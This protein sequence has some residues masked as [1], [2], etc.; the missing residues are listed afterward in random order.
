MEKLLKVVVFCGGRGAANIIRAFHDYSRVELTV[1]V[2]AFDDGLSTGR[3][4]RFIPGMLGPSDVRKNI[5]SLIQDFDASSTALKAILEYRFPDPTPREA[6]L[7]CLTAMVER[8]RELPCPDLA[9]LYQAL[10]I[11]QINWIADYLGAFLRYEQEQFDHG[12]VFEYGDTSV[13]NLLFS[14]CHLACNRDF[15]QASQVFQE[16]CQI[17]GRVLNITDGS[18]QVLTGLRETGQFLPD[19]ATIVAAH[20]DNAKIADLF[21]LP[22]YLTPA[23]RQQLDALTLSERHAWLGRRHV[24]PNL[25]PHAR[26]ALE[27][28]DLIIYGPGTQH[29]SLYP[30]YMVAGVRRTIEQNDKAEKVFIGNIRPDHDIPSATVQ[31]LIERFFY[32][33]S[34][35]QA[36]QPQTTKLIT[37]LFVQESDS[38]RIELHASRTAYLPLN[39]NDIHIDSRYITIR[40]WEES[41]GRHSGDQIISE[42][43]TLF[44]QLHAFK[45]QPHRFLVS[46]VVPALNEQRTV[47]RVL[48]ELIHLDFTPLGIG[49]E[50]LFIDGGSEDGTLKEA[51]KERFVRCFQ[52]K[53]DARGRGAA[54]RL[55]IAKAKGNIIVLFPADGEY[56][57]QDIFKVVTPI[58]ANQFQVVFGS[59]AI[60]CLDIDPVIKKIYGK[61]ST[62][63]FVSKYGGLILSFL[64]LLFFNRYLSDPLSSLKAFDAK[65]LRSFPLVS[66]GMDLDLEI[67]ARVHQ[68]RTYI[69]EVPVEYSPRTL[70][71]GKKTTL[72][73]GPKTLYRFIVCK[74]SP[75]PHP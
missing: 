63:Y 34:D 28:A 46:I 39:I 9:H 58:V 40:D 3:L 14:G 26:Q 33:M 30:S 29:S 67:I 32:F 23:E 43:L 75:P 37:R 72:A 73:G 52:L 71:E 65:L 55:G 56:V 31:E 6:A 53:D 22:D 20:S 7:T 19:E 49:K 57:A 17:F 74:L 25:N 35:K 21:L 4:R 68:S 2:N 62:M 45:L 16:K 36:R 13:G 47:R 48:Q 8:V 1:L 38:D 27:E 66:Q 5:I 54:I 44:K 12:I 41:A 60:K 64:S 24:V 61:K 11:R 70:I 15:N 51:L 10:K 69:L 59:R 42:L 50:I 18:H